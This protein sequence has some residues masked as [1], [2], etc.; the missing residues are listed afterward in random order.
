MGSGTKCQKIF[1]KCLRRPDFGDPHPSPRAQSLPGRDISGSGGGGGA[2]NGDAEEQFPSLLSTAL[3][4]E[5]ETGAM[6]L[7]DFVGLV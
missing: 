5:H 6:D 2:M 3:W 1:E 7:S 4:A